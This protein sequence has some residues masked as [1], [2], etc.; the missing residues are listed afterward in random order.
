L[1]SDTA[2]VT[3]NRTCSRHLGLYLCVEAIACAADDP[4]TIT[5]QPDGMGKVTSYHLTEPEYRTIIG[6]QL[7]MFLNGPQQI[8]TYTISVPDA[9][10]C[11]VSETFDIVYACKSYQLTLAHPTDLCYVRGETES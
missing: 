4:V 10:G 11:T 6:P 9:G 1:F 7:A 3:V 8:G 2:T 5:A